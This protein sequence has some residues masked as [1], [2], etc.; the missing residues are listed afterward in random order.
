MI[1]QKLYFLHLVL[2][3]YIITPYTCKYILSPLLSQ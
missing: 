1:A 2:P 3:Y